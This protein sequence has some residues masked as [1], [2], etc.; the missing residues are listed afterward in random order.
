MFAEATIESEAVGG[1]AP[2]V[3][4]ESA[5]LFTGRRSVVFVDVP[6]ALDP[7]YELR[8]VRLGPRTGPVYPVLAGLNEGERVVTSGAFVWM[9]DVQLRG[10]RS[11]MTM[12]DDVSSAPAPAPEVSLAFRATLRPVVEAYLEAQLHLANDDLDAARE[13]LR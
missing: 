6:Q 3:I 8:V 10:G 2:L 1:V 11:M 12:P 9:P 4:P 7:T 13:S 5:P